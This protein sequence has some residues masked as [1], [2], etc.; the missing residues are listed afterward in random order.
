MHRILWLKAWS[1][2]AANKKRLTRMPFE[3]GCLFGEALHKFMK[4]V[5]GGQVLFFCPSEKFQN[6]PQE[7]LSPKNTEHLRNN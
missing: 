4:D 1:V 6:L 3:G 5:T 2:K 7:S